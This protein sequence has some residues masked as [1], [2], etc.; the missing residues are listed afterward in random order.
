M[1]DRLESGGVSEEQ[2]H[3]SAH[4]NT[5]MEPRGALGAPSFVHLS[6]RYGSVS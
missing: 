1:D 3:V 5:E 2:D 6:N 4:G